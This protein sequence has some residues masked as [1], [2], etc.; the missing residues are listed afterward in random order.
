[1]LWSVVRAYPSKLKSIERERERERKRERKKERAHSVL[2]LLFFF[3]RVFYNALRWRKTQRCWVSSYNDDLRS[4]DRSNHHIYRATGGLCQTTFHD[5]ACHPFHLD[6][7]LRSCLLTQTWGWKESHHSVWCQSVMVS[8][9]KEDL[10]LLGK[11]G[12]L[13]GV[14]GPDKRFP[15]CLGSCPDNDEKCDIWTSRNDVMWTDA[16]KYFVGGHVREDLYIRV[17]LSLCSSRPSSQGFD[18]R[19]STTVLLAVHTSDACTIGLASS[20]SAS[21]FPKFVSY[22][23]HLECLWAKI[24][25]TVER[26][27]NNYWS[28]QRLLTSFVDASR[29]SKYEA[30]ARNLGHSCSIIIINIIAGSFPLSMGIST[31]HINHV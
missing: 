11:Y 12:S 16:W 6:D 10:R 24:W 20:Q 19:P 22:C 3:N 25:P 18:W 2:I 8:Y 27:I 30:G 7:A 31:L 28:G 15:E 23:F 5:R 1:M 21:I 29:F 4:R 14:N 13:S 26:K 17:K 9:A